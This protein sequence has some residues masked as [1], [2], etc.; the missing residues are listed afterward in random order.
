MGGHLCAIATVLFTAH[1]F[2]SNALAY[3]PHSQTIIN[4]IVK[5]HGKGSYV[6]EQDVQ[7]RTSTEPLILHERW[8]IENGE[9]MRVTV[10]APSS[11]KT[12]DPIRYDAIY[13]GNR[14]TVTDPGSGAKTIAT[15]PEFIE[16]F[17][18]DRSARGLTNSMIQARILP[19]SFLRD[20]P[21]M[22]KIE[23]IKYA[24]EPDLRLGR[25]AGVVAWI[26]GQPSPQ[27]G[28]LSPEAW[29]AQDLF[30][31]LKLRF[32]SEAEV[33]ADRYTAYA[34]ALKLPRERTVA[35]DGNSATIRITSVRTV[36]PG[37]LGRQLEPDSLNTLAKNSRLP[38]LAQVREFYSRFR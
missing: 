37:Q 12:A 13:R 26:F 10:T 17:F 30:S 19:P 2:A 23:Q 6:V 34:G 27:Q 20:R 29:I 1:F 35:W 16:S 38:D 31:I 24:P 9:N 5:S 33:T 25:D 3:I 11:V 21:K 32:S 14:R 36:T 7:F 22:Q 4:R 8:L 18:H 15:S 28:P